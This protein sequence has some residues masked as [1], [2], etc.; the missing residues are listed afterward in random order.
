MTCKT[1]QWAEWELTPT[2]RISK[3]KPGKCIVKT[4]DHP[5]LPSCVR[6]LFWPPLR[7]AIWHNE[8]WEC[9]T[10]SPQAMGGDS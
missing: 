2:R 1:C 8:T 3:S 7:F 9:E 4:A 5:P 10:Y 6:D